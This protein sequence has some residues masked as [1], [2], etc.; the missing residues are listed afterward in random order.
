[1]AGF[2]G[3]AGAGAALVQLLRDHLCPDIVDSPDKICL[4]HPMES[5]NLSLGV[6]LYDIQENGE[7][8][9]TDMLTAGLDQQRFP[10]L[11]LTL[12]YMITG[13]V[14]SGILIPKVIQ[15]IYDHSALKPF[16]KEAPVYIHPIGLTAKE[17]MDLWRF[18]P[19]PYHLSLFYSLSPVFLESTRSIK[20]SRVVSSEFYLKE[21]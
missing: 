16:E 9:Q 20:I 13:Y 14:S 4:C 1:M 15:I 2:T 17:K 11:S 7:S 21:I 3:I 18:P 10:P 8:R 12:N 19:L 5:A 6:Y